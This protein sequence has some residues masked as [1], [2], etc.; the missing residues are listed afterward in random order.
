MHGFAEI[1]LIDDLSHIPLKFN[2]LRKAPGFMLDWY[3]RKFNPFTAEDIQILGE[4][5][6]LIK[7]PLTALDMREH[8]EYFNELAARTLHSLRDYEVGIVL[9]PT[10]SVSELTEVRFPDILPTAD[11]RLVFALFIMQAIEKTLNLTGKN[12]KTAEIIII[13][14]SRN[15]TMSALDII[16]PHVNYLTLITDLNYSE[17]CAQVFSD[18]G[19][20]VNVSNYNR[21][22][23]ENADIIINT[24]DENKYD[25]YFKRGAVFFQLA[26]RNGALIAAKRDDVLIVDGLRLSCDMAMER[27]TAIS[28]E[29]FECGL[30]T[31]SREYRKLKSGYSSRSIRP[32]TELINTLGY[33]VRGL[34]LCGKE[35][36]GRSF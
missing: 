11:G 26:H 15:L 27:G 22:S 10:Q 6:Y 7:M 19:L 20:N 30:H 5:G 8:P 23:L 1:K 18:C 32:V 16:Y 25:Y 12:I 21:S 35:A 31:M 14:G 17:K 2:I 29:R 33:S 3:I 36:R 34:L 28:L 24:C 9:P 13:D 4:H